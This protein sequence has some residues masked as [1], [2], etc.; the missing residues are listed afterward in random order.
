[1]LIQPKQAL[2]RGIFADD[3]CGLV[4]VDQKNDVRYMWVSV[5]RQNIDIRGRGN[6]R[7][8]KRHFRGRYIRWGLPSGR[9]MRPKI[10]TFFVPYHLLLY[11]GKYGINDP[12]SRN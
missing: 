2:E 7:S 12:R 6:S 11:Q 1:M 9:Y 4:L 8:G 5:S 3:W 10:L